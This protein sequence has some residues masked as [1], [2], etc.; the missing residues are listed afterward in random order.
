MRDT[1]SDQTFMTTRT[2]KEAIL[3]MYDRLYLNILYPFIFLHLRSV[4]THQVLAIDMVPMMRCCKDQGAAQGLHL[5]MYAGA[6]TL[7][8]ITVNL[9]PPLLFSPS[10]IVK[11]LVD[12]SSSMKETCY[13][14]DD[15]MT[16]LDAV[17]Q[18]F[19][20]FTTRSMA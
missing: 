18:L 3:V 2:P 20:N 19:D 13:D 15:K 12:S 10:N 1:R 17:K 5:R 16:R 4:L 11:V 14:S 8:I 6:T 9:A 7:Y